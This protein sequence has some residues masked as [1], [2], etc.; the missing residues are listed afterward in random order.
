MFKL[1]KNKKSTDEQELEANINS[2][3]SKVI[4]KETVLIKLFG[5]NEYIL[6]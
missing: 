1:I 3:L 6:Y 2:T 4:E 5:Y